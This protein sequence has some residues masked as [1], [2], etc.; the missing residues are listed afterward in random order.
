MTKIN[1]IYKCNICGNIVE[2][3]HAGAGELVCCGQPMVLQ[4]ENTVDAAKEKHIPVKEIIG[5]KVVVKIGTVEHPMTAEHYIEWVEVVTKARVY[6][7]T[8]TPGEKPFA[9]FDIQ[10]EVIE[11]RAYCN[12]HGLWKT[13]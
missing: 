3:V 1:Q 12:L 11:V 4:V 8:F 9:E 6:R 7:K 10:E 2:V 5:D 13:N